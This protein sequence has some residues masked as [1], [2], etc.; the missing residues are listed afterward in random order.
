MDKQSIINLLH[1]ENCSCVIV[2]GDIVKVCR[3]RGVKDLLSVLHNSPELLVG[4]FIADKVVG[5]GAAALMI[6]G[7]VSNVYADVISIPAL[8][9]L[10]DADIPVSYACC[11]PNIIN[12]AHTGVCPV[13]TL[14]ANCKTAA[15]CLPIIEQFIQQLPQC[16]QH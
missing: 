4:S 16:N 11:V 5:K 1:S 14:C 12:R 9:M 7:C 8:S 10:E 6:L 15:E 13:E 2:N 3:Q